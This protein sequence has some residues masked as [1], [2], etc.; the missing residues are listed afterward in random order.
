MVQFVRQSGIYCSLTLSLVISFRFLKQN[1]IGQAGIFDFLEKPR[2]TIELTSS[3][4]GEYIIC[5]DLTVYCQCLRRDQP[6]GL[7]IE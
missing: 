5:K 6:M 2:P 4:K 3:I 1:Q 7:L